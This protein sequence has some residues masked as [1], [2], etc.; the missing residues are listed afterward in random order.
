MGS[1]RFPG[2]P[3]APL[4]GRPMIE[5][6]FRRSSMCPDLESVWVATC[7][8]EIREA[9]EAFGGRVL[10]TSASHA[11]A[12]DRVAE[13]ANKIQADIVI[14][15]QG[16]EPMVTPYM[17]S[18]AV[19]PMLKD[20]TI[21]CVNLTRRITREEEYRDPNTIKVVMNK[22]NDALYFSR[23]PIP[24]LNVTR[25]DSVPIF[26]QVCVIPFRRDFL[27][28]L[29]ELPPTPLEQAES[30]DMLRAIEHGRRVRMVETDVETHSV[31]TPADLRL[32]SELMKD[33]PLL[34]AYQTSMPR[35]AQAK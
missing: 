8:E 9:V 35:A 3:L 29:T 24:M 14:M 16:D 17:I 13:A 5:H 23:A 11:R 10:M 33:D 25:F 22:K 30:I 28:D 2:K 26:K 20:R 12:T 6:L 15:I 21:E 19:N 1:S 31:D 32:V 4:L 34:A 7:D 18:V 27:R